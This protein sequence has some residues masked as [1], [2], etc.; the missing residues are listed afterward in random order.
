MVQHQDRPDGSRRWRRRQAGQLQ[1]PGLS[2]RVRL[3][4]RR[5]S[6]FVEACSHQ[7]LHLTRGEVDPEGETD[8]I[9]PQCHRED[10]G[11]CASGG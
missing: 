7:P 10:S 8:P 4:L 2:E 1:Q 9:P 5:S 6:H 11:Q 3:S